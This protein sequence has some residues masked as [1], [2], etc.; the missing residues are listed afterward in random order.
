MLEEMVDDTELPAKLIA[1]EG[2]L[3]RILVADEGL[4]GSKLVSDEGLLGS[5]LVVV[6]LLS[7]K[8]ATGG[9]S[10]GASGRPLV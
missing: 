1:D 9:P 8:W 6:V 2:L 7:L 10:E 5:K 4:L 3:G